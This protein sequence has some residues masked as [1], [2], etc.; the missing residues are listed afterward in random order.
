MAK[1][2]NRLYFIVRSII[3]NTI[4]GSLLLSVIWY[5][6]SINFVESV[7]IGTCIFIFSLAFSRLFD[8]KIERLVGKILK[9]LN[10]HKELKRII[11]NYF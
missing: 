2:K 1:G 6:K 9:V 7:T 5:M 3:L 4:S 8:S 10:K 11:L